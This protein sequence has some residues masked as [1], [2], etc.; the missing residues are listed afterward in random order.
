MLIGDW[1][2]AFVTQRNDSASGLDCTVATSLATAVYKLML[3]SQRV[4][5]GPESGW[6]S[7]AIVSVGVETTG[8]IFPTIAVANA[9]D[10]AMTQ[11]TRAL[12]ASNSTA[13]VATRLEWTATCQSLTDVSTCPQDYSTVRYTCQAKV[14]M[15]TCLFVFLSGVLGCGHASGV[16]V[17]G[18]GG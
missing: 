14:T 11:F 7:E 3:A 17:W 10:D 8:A 9:V 13:S 6:R 15:K 12:A 4:Q 18:G 5:R 1:I 16:C 2:D